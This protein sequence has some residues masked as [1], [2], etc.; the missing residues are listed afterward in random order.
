MDIYKFGGTSQKD[1]A[2]LDCC[3]NLL[4]VDSAPKVSVNSTIGG[5]TNLLFLGGQEQIKTGLFPQIQYQKIGQL[6]FEVYSAVPNSKEIIESGMEDL[7]RRIVRGER[8]NLSNSTIADFHLASLA[9]FGEFLNAQLF[10]NYLQQRKIKTILLSP[11]RLKGEPLN[12]DYDSNSNFSLQKEV[13][14]SLAQVYVIPGYYGLNEQQQE[15]VFSRGGSD[16]TQTLIARALNAEHCFNCTDVSGI[17]PIDPKLLTEDSD[18]ETLQPIPSLNYLE[19]QQLSYNGAKVLHPR[20]LR[21]L[22]DL[23]IPLIVL[24]SFAPISG[25]T[26]ISSSLGNKSEIKAV[27]GRHQKFST[28]ELMAGEMEG[29]RGYLAA[30]AQ[31]CSHLDLDTITTADAGISATTTDEEAAVR[32][33]VE[34]LQRLGKVSYHNGAATIA[35]VGSHLGSDPSIL[36]KFFNILATEKIKVNQVTKADDFSLRA[37]I[38]ATDYSRAILAL[39]H[40]L[41]IN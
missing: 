21:P 25:A 22:I 1:A 14:N 33:A 11:L 23:G 2:A 30:F 31:A 35:I 24:N 18:L 37:V 7:K 4:S 38:S 6:F 19:A 8:N 16:Y 3:Y 26:I 5:V 12:A 20:C 27:T 9:A 40:G 34:K 41:I 29:Q 39:Y 10:S 28:L 17:F 36:A 15:V 13:R 32:I